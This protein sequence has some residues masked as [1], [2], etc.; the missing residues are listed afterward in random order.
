MMKTLDQWLASFSFQPGD[1]RDSLDHFTP[2][3]SALDVQPLA[4]KV[5]TVTGTNGKGS[6]VELLDE[7]YR[8]AGYRVAKFTSPHI[9]DFRE[10]LLID[11]EMV[12]SALVAES[13]E[14][15]SRVSSS[16]SL[17]T[18][19]F[20]F[21]GLFWCIRQSDVDVALLE[22]GLGG[23][24]DPCNLFDSDVAIITSIGLDHQDR[25]GD[26]VEAIAYEKSCLARAGRP[27][28]CGQPSP[29]KTVRQVVSNVGGCLYQVGS[30][31]GFG[32]RAREGCWDWKSPLQEY[33]DLPIPKIK[34]Q[35]AATALMAVECMQTPLAVKEGVIR[36]A[37]VRVSLAGRFEVI[38]RHC[39]IV[40]DVA[41][42]EA[43]SVHLA[44]QL[45][46]TPVTG[47]TFF[48]FGLAH[49]KALYT[50]LQA[51]A[52][53]AD[54]WYVAPLSGGKKSHHPDEIQR[55]LEVLGEKTCYTSDDFSQ[56][57]HL[58]YINAGPDDRIVVCGSFLAVASMKRYLETN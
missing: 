18:F 21:L 53:V 35:N 16:V 19:E 58:A 49:N 1:P 11:G 7:I 32:Y 56:A 12:S 14:R 36:E 30:D 23:R 9:T 4:P 55:Q 39:L 8:R 46:A 51:L 6:V 48:V 31:T 10:R 17:S 54:G 47:K 44:H 42:N 22:V 37:L 27:L 28:I 45:A 57:L 33:R 52:P 50:V 25:L 20:F 2:Y 34:L 29:P 43:A 41:H 5:I 13:F 40:L 24:L 38:R 15:V 3:L 26:T